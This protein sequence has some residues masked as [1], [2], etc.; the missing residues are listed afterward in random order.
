MHKLE[1]NSSDL[2]VC[3]YDLNLK[4][5]P[6]APERPLYFKTSLGNSQTIVA[7]FINFCRQKTDYSCKVRIRIASHTATR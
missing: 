2:G 3:V 6:P 4:A 1:L 7:K 5:T